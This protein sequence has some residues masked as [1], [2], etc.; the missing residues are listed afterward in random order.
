MGRKNSN[1]G[2]KHVKRTERRQ[3]GERLYAFPRED[4]S[5]QVSSSVISDSLSQR[6]FDGLGEMLKAA[7]V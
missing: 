7:L 5:L 3:D 4:G 6:P 2:V 1:A